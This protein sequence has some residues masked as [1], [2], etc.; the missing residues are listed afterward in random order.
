MSMHIG[1]NNYMTLQGIDKKAVTFA[2][3]QNNTVH[4]V[5]ACNSTACTLIFN[6]CSKTSCITHHYTAT[7]ILN[8]IQ[9]DITL[10]TINFVYTAYPC[11]VNV[12]F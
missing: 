8:Q 1:P 6:S 12:Y 11:I 2:Q 3:L 5:G 4:G 9:F 7:K 10:N